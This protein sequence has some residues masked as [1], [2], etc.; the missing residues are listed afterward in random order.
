[1]CSVNVVTL[2]W[3]S[4]QNLKQSA[5]SFNRL[6]PVDETQVVRHGDSCLYP[7]RHLFS[8]SIMNLNTFMSYDSTPVLMS[9]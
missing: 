7:L 3:R 6:A 1:M 4:E 2:M 8:L 5:L 9:V